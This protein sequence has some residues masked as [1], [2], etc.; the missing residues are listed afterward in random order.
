[1]AK[2]NTDMDEM[3]KDVHTHTTLTKSGPTMSGGVRQGF[4]TV[5][6]TSAHLVAA[7]THHLGLVGREE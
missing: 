5:I 6:H 4:L 1:M 7:D 2:P 3:K